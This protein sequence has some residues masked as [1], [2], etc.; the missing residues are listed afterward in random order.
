MK[1][2]SQ[3]DAKAWHAELAETVLTSWS[4][5]ESGLSQAEVGRR[6]HQYGPNVLPWRLRQK[7]RI[8]QSESAALVELHRG[9]L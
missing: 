1:A 9:G 8:P 6:Q 2:F 7:F 3:Q 5:T 4:T